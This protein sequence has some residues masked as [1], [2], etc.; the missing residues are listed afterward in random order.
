MT[1]YLSEHIK[2]WLA[3][4]DNDLLSASRLMDIEPVI[5]DNACFFCQ[6]AAE[7]YLKAFLAFKEHDF[8]KTHNLYYLLEECAK[9]DS[10]FSAI[11]IKDLSA[12]AVQVRYPDS[13][14]LP[15]VKEAKEYFHITEHIRDFV[16]QR[17]KIA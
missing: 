5:L 16:K 7:K 3:K 1:K 10:A 11:E 15:T 9:Y 2:A 8:E 14:V 12:F 13:S 6:Q 17:I 4:A